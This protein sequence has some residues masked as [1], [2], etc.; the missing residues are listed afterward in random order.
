MSGRSPIESWLRLSFIVQHQRLL[1][2]LCTAFVSRDDT[3]P[4]TI[5]P[6]FQASVLNVKSGRMGATLLYCTLNIHHSPLH[7]VGVSQLSI[8]QGAEEMAQQFRTSASR[9][10]KYGSQLPCQAAH[11]SYSASSSNS[12]S[13]FWPPRASV[14]L[15]THLHRDSSLLWPPRASVPLYTHPHT[16]SS[17][18]WPP[19]ASVSLCTHPHTDVHR[20]K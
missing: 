1:P 18:F 4:S 14:P 11:N 12:G 10:P 2:S 20:I 16:D 19:R 7:G 8:H 13:L 17:L 6:P 15:H 9:G 3:G 5:T